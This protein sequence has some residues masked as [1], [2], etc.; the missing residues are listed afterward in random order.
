MGG[1][2]AANELKVGTR[3]SWFDQP[4]SR[5]GERE[6]SGVRGREGDVG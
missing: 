4:V 2:R 6:A 5:E 3:E 1:I